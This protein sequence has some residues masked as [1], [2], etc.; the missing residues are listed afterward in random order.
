MVYV[1]N[2]HNLSVRRSV[3]VLPQLTSFDAFNKQE[4]TNDKR[5]PHPRCWH[6][7]DVPAPGLPVFIIIQWNRHM[8][9]PGECL[10]ALNE[11]TE[12]N[13]AENCRMPSDKDIFL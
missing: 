12:K 3:D 5:G 7:Q 2:T 8:E 1:G 4:V 11:E 6:D 9:D 10:L 13:R